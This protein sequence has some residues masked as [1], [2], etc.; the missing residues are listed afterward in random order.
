MKNLEIKNINCRTALV[1]D[2]K[3]AQTGRSM[4][5]MLGVLAIIGVLSV[6]GIAG[7][8]K[9][10]MKY[11]INKT[12]EQ[13]TITSQNI[14]SFFANQPSSTR[15]SS[16]NS[17]GACWGVLAGS[18]NKPC[19]GAHIIRK[20]KLVSDDMIDSSFRSEDPLAI[21]NTA[22]KPINGMGNLFGGEIN[23]QGSG[24]IFAIRLRGI[25]QEACVDLVTQDW[26]SVSAGVVGLML[27]SHSAATTGNKAN[28][29][30]STSMPVSIDVA[31]NWC[32]DTNAFT[33]Y[34]E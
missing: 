30:S 26:S 28:L 29:Y 5:E 11:R 15:Y 13:I 2:T 17:E 20:A 23:I 7:Y 32:A 6:G 16:L 8:S 19:E 33:L 3:N 25:P 24:A 27:G 22:N 14:R 21:N 34:Y 18:N 12:I 4:I 10:M 1:I 9:A 31:T